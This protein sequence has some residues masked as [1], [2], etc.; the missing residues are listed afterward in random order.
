M[1]RVGGNRARKIRRGPYPP[2]CGLCPPR[3]AYI[4]PS[5]KICMSRVVMLGAKRVEDALSRLS[6]VVGENRKYTKTEKK[7]MKWKKEKK[8]YGASD[9][10][11][12]PRVKGNK[13]FKGSK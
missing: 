7:W 4:L 12:R 1:C 11:L 9:R 8:D 6:T 3:V 5:G 2:T 13:G 10:V